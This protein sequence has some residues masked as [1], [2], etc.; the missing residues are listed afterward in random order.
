MKLIDKSSRHQPQI[1]NQVHIAGIA[2]KRFDITIQDGRFASIV[3]TGPHRAEAESPGQD[4]WISPGVI[5]LHTHLAWTD[6]DHADQLKRDPHEI[7]VMQA[8]AFA[9]TLRTGVTTARDAGGIRPGTVRHIV[10][11]YGHPLRVHAC[12]DMLGAADARRG[13]GHLEL[14]LQQ[15]FDTGAGWIKIM[16]TGGLGAPT[17][18]VLDPTF[19]EEEFASIVRHAHAH[20][21][22]VLVHTWGGVTIDWSIAAGVES[23]EHGMFLTEDQAGRL[24]ASGVAFVPTTSIYRIAAD[25]KGVLA[26]NQAICDRAAR[27]AEA[28]PKAIAYA[29]RAGVRIGFGTDYATPLLH[30]HNLQE[31]DTLMDYGL[32][33]SDAWQAATT[34]AADILGSGRELGRIAEGYLADAILFNADPYQARNAEQLRKSIV[35]V[36]TGAA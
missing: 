27:A 3:E 11:H 35:S 7:E 13:L 22:K 5:D 23:I 10:Q 20:H 2:G 12:S 34:T 15:I 16:A 30:G 21:K 4:L 29:Q 26:L 32:S 8:E 31:L 24:A 1:L 19:S 17:E 14:R 36:I 6:F 9:A 25:P 28:H 18:K 33:W